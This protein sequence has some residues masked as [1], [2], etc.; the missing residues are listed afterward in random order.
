MDHLGYGPKPMAHIAYGP[1][2]M[3]HLNNL[4]SSFIDPEPER[5]FYKILLILAELKT[6]ISVFKI[7]NIFRRKIFFEGI[8]RFF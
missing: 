5:I 3:G 6:I 7:S 2:P 8:R 4:Y 1:K